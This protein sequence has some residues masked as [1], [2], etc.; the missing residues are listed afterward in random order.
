M[1][2]HAHYN[3]VFCLFEELA[4][5]DHDRFRTVIDLGEDGEISGGAERER[6]RGES[7]THTEACCN[8]DTPTNA[9]AAQ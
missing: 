3:E 4:G 5:K 7:K 9:L 8:C 1:R 2:V 6:E